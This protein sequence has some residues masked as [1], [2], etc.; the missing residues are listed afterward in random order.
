MCPLSSELF[1]YARFH[2]L[3]VLLT[4][5]FNGNMSQFNMPPYILLCF[6]LFEDICHD[7]TDSSWVFEDNT[8]RRVFHV[9]SSSVHD[10][11]LLLMVRI[12][13]GGNTSFHGI[14]LF[15]G[16]RFNQTNF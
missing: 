8:T 3:N 7:E 6:L 10:H 5:L 1:N 12:L 15:L 14:T 4:L 11:E 2:D 9:N 13:N 16:V